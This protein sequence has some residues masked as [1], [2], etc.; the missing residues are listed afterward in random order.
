MAR[1][2][3]VATP[4]T[5]ATVTVLAPEAKSPP[6]SVRVT[7]ELSPATVEPTEFTTET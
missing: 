1:L 5:A 2:L 4:P 7:G 3:K 6:L